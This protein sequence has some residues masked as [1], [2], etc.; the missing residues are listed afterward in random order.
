M[1]YGVDHI[2]IL[3]ML[4]PKYS[5]SSIRGSPYMEDQLISNPELN[6]LTLDLDPFTDNN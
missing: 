1:K 2:D 3:L 6:Q 4:P 5:V